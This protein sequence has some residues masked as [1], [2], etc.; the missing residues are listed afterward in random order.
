MNDR[1]ILAHMHNA[2]IELDNRL[3]AIEK[4]LM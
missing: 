1:P 4:K 2:I 3:K